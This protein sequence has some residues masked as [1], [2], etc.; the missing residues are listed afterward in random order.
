MDNGIF[1]Q[2]IAVKF[3]MGCFLLMSYTSTEVVQLDALLGPGREPNYLDFTSAFRQ[4][5]V[6]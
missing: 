1:F 5:I 3:S 6:E 4:G 2:G